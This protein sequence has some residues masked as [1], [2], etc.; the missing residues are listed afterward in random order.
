MNG[1]SNFLRNWLLSQDLCPK[2]LQEA[3]DQEIV[4]DL[5]DGIILCDL[6]NK[7]KPGTILDIC[8]DAAQYK[9]K[10]IS[11]LRKFIRGC[12][13]FPLDE[14]HLFQPSEYYSG[15]NFPKVLACL[16]SLHSTI[17]TP[18]N[19]G[20]SC[21]TTIPTSTA[22]AIL[23]PVPKPRPDLSRP[24]VPQKPMRRAIADYDFEKSRTD[25]ISF[26]EGD[27]IIL[28]NTPEGG[29]WQGEL[30]GVLGW[31]PCNFVHE[32]P[33]SRKA[34]DSTNHLHSGGSTGTSHSSLSSV[35]H[36][37]PHS[38]EALFQPPPSHNPYR[39]AVVMDILKSE[40]EYV[41]YLRDFITL[42]LVPLQRASWLQAAEKEHLVSNVD[43]IEEFQASFLRELEVCSQ[44]A[45]AD[46]R[47]GLLFLD[48]LEHIREIYV[49]YVEMSPATISVLEK[50]RS[51]HDMNDFLK[52]RGVDFVPPTLS[53]SLYFT[54]PI[55]RLSKYAS[56]LE[57]L[58]RYTADADPD[59]SSLKQSVFRYHR[60]SEDI[61]TIKKL[62]EQEFSLQ[63][64]RI[65]GWDVA[66]QQGQLV[67]ATWLLV[68]PKDKMIE[69]RWF[70]LYPSVLMILAKSSKAKFHYQLK[71]KLMLSNLVV[72]DHPEA[73]GLYMFDIV[74]S[75]N[76]KV[77]SVSAN[78]SKE[79]RQFLE[80]LELC[81]QQEP[82]PETQP[83]ERRTLRSKLAKF[84]HKGKNPSGPQNQWDSSQTSSPTSTLAP[85]PGPP[86]NISS[87]DEALERHFHH[88]TTGSIHT[89]GPP[90][91][92]PFSGIHY[93]NT[94]PLTHH[95]DAKMGS[96]SAS[97]LFCSL[98]GDEPSLGMTPKQKQR[99][100]PHMRSSR[101]LKGAVDGAK[102]VA[103]CFSECAEG[104]S[105][106]GLPGSTLGLVPASLD[107]VC[108]AV[109]DLR[110]QMESMQAEMDLLRVKL[111]DECQ[112]RKLL[113]TRLSSYL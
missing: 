83:A 16:K 26:K 23:P 39:H 103:D 86:R 59:K 5:R 79:K 111:S 54:K 1:E 21:P 52:Q 61:Q 45:P 48:S 69:E 67:A 7:I 4:A 84:L 36:L 68:H 42:Y 60:L 17:P 95:A 29:W 101:A 82:L 72:S 88:M 10:A 15:T 104:A 107:E 77:L 20:A 9:Y 46:Q 38:E 113:E 24:A 78:S 87:S 97:L 96:N 73:E 14:T 33:G 49:D 28:K 99:S 8:R 40:R 11:N 53:L 100:L 57:E 76:M 98:R 56:L 32:V 31:F 85:F 34:S 109:A 105:C 70:L 66:H 12:Q 6:L 74:N 80:A 92:A 3:S 43:E 41:S 62:R 18:N 64:S 93:S 90:C 75:S 25:E 102:P 19:S 65:D 91:G 44:L 108:V 89:S 27:L 58:D 30:N 47:I 37:K 2:H 112:Q 106:L 13:S 22:L 55:Q 63:K 94:V 51:N 110:S 81:K 35:G 50:Y 71:T